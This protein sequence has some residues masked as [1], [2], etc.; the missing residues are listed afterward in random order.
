MSKPPPSI[1]GIGF[2]EDT[3]GPNSNCCFWTSESIKPLEFPGITLA[4]GFSIGIVF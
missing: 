1:V 2:K 3:E 4:L